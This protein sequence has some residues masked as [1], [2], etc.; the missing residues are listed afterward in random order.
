MAQRNI[1]SFF[2][3]PSG[4][5]RARPSENDISPSIAG[6][7]SDSRFTSDCESELGDHNELTVPV[8]MISDIDHEHLQ[9]E[10]ARSSTV[11]NPVCDAECCQMHITN[12]SWISYCI[13]LHKA[14]CF[15]CRFA[16]SKSLISDLNKSSNSYNAFVINGFDNWKKAKQRLREHKRSQLH[17]EATMKL[18]SLN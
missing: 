13:T 14:F 3:S 12:H 8:T 9:T 10:S 2:K 11:I 1:T 16:A 7:D 4:S 15:S 6:S 5:K 17:L 18:Q